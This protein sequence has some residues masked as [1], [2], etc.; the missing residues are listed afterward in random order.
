M[1][2]DLAAFNVGIRTAAP[3]GSRLIDFLLQISAIDFV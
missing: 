3:G 2:Y 1:P